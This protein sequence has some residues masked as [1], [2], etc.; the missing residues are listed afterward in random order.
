MS[1]VAIVMSLHVS[2]ASS[3]FGMFGRK[4]FGQRCPAGVLSIVVGP[5]TWGVTW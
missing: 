1:K 5:K 2:G 4:R 3:E